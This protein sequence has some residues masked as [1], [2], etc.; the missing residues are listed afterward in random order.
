MMII[1]YEICGCN[2]SWLNVEISP[3]MTSLVKKELKY[4][5]QGTFE[6][7]NILHNPTF[8]PDFDL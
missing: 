1:F 2:L 8:D 3:R 4:Q 6:C 5:N 7:R